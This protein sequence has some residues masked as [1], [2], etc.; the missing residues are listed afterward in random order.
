LIGTRQRSGLLDE[1]SGTF[2]LSSFMSSG[3]IEQQTSRVMRLTLDLGVVG[4]NFCHE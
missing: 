2:R 4:L 1:Y 3:K